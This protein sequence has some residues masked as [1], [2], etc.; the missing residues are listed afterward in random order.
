VRN[1]SNISVGITNGS[2]LKKRSKDKD[3][4]IQDVS[5]RASQL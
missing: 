4:N 2:N 1:A 3:L 5:E